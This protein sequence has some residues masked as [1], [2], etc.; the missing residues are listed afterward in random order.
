MKRLVPLAFALLLSQCHAQVAIGG[1][2]YRLFPDCSAR[3]CGVSYYVSHLSQ[4][5]LTEVGFDGG[6]FYYRRSTSF[7]VSTHD[8]H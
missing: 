8:G 1:T 7:V 6:K 4:Q 5:D 2:S 3:G